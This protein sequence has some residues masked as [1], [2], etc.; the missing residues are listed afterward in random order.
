MTMQVS[1][2]NDQV[3]VSE[4]FP[5]FHMPRVWVWTQEFRS[6]VADDF[7]PKSLEEFMAVQQARVAAG[8]RSWGV[9]R[10]GELGGLVTFEPTSPICGAAH[11]IFKKSFWGHETTVEAMRLVFDEVFASGVRKIL[12]LA[13]ADN[14]QLMY[15]V[16]LLGFQKEGVLRKQTQRGGELVDMMALG[17]TH[18]DFQTACSAGLEGMRE[19][20]RAAKVKRFARM[21][22]Q[23]KAA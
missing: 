6:R 19:K 7:G 11:C 21:D 1:A 3:R 10:G 16:R 9:Y 5:A 4:P 18:D 20:L 12:S 15:A 2:I 23:G 17:C 8:L 13:F 14:V 22:A